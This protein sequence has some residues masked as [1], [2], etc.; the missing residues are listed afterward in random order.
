MKGYLK[1]KKQFRKNGEFA[2]GH[3]INNGKHRSPATEF[4]KGMISWCKGTKGL[5]KA[6]NKGTKGL[7]KVNKGSFKKGIT[8]WNKGIEFKKIQWDK[9]P[10]FKGGYTR[11]VN[12]LKR[13]GIKPI[14][15][16]CNKEGFFSN[17]IIVHHKNKNKK[18]NMINNLQVLCSKY[19]AHKHKNWEKR[20]G[21]KNV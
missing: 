17:K 16:I 7:M 20:W 11:Y 6:W 13:I 3:T 15:S 19:H 9:H 1:M 8:P 4:K 21:V 5:L 2:K 18:N 14:C 12:L 10:L